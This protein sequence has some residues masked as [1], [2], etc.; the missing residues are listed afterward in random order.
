[1][2]QTVITKATLRRNPDHWDQCDDASR[3]D[4]CHIDPTV[5]VIHGPIK[6]G[7]E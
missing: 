5:D 7:D 6:I 4:I 1:M 3:T 2:A